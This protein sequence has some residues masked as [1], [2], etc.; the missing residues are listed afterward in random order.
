MVDHADHTGALP[1]LGLHKPRQVH[2]NIG[3]D[4]RRDLATNAGGSDVPAQPKSD[5]LEEAIGATTP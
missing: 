2:S 1:R 4:G 3:G 5:V